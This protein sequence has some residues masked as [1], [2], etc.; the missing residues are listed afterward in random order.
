M[1]RFSGQ[2]HLQMVAQQVV[3]L[4]QVQMV[5]GL[6]HQPE[7]TE[8]KQI[9]GIS[10]VLKT[11]MQQAP[12]EQVVATMLHC[13]LAMLPVRRL[14]HSFAPGAIAVLLMMQQTRKLLQTKELNH[15][16]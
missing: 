13:I 9:P 1:H 6:L 15:L 2:K 12:A 3:Q 16:Q 14:L 8:Q 7:Q 4:S 10:V 5:R 11:E